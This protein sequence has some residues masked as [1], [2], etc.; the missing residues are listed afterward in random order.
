MTW[1]V[2]G[3]STL[4]NSTISYPVDMLTKNVN[5]LNWMGK[6]V[7][8]Y[9]RIF[10]PWLYEWCFCRSN[11]A[12]LCSVCRNSCWLCFC[13]GPTG[14][15]QPRRPKVWIRLLLLSTRWGESAAIRPATIPEETAIMSH[16]SQSQLHHCHCWAD[17]DRY[18]GSL[19]LRH[20][21]N[22]AKQ[23]THTS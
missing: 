14:E 7:D 2:V 15:Q 20:L 19:H 11:I 4:L 18:F 6:T 12:R 23:K 10:G 16:L 1:L 8:T 21:E 17:S 13:A 5:N 3:L 9:R 22:L